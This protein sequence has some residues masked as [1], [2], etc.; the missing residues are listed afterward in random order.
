M[1]ENLTSALIAGLVALVV[2]VIS[3]IV[4]SFTSGKT[5]KHAQYESKRTGITVQRMNWIAEIRKIFA[6]LMAFD[7]ETLVT[8]QAKQD[9]FNKTI[10]L[11]KLYLNF[12]G[13][14]DEKILDSLNVLAESVSNE[15]D[16]DSKGTF[17][18]EQRNIQMHA[19][20]YLKSEWNRVKFES[21]PENI[22]RKYNEEEAIKDLTEKYKK[23]EKLIDSRPEREASNVREMLDIHR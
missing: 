14:I 21:D 13:K 11:L 5:L 23:A 8:K 4:T 18:R 22:S 7:F 12:S 3:A 15:V 20:I 2:A 10:Q 9:E 1:S 17:E 16:N 19:H 6:E